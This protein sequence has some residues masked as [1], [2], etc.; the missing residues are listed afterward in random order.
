[1]DGLVSTELMDADILKPLFNYGKD[2]VCPS[3]IHLIK[4]LLLEQV[5][6]AAHISEGQKNWGRD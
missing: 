2:Q 1:M 4:Q 5:I 3:E 6:T